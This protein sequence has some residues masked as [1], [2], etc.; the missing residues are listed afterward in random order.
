MNIRIDKAASVTVNV[1]LRNSVSVDDIKNVKVGNVCIVRALEEKRVYEKL[2]L[3]T[4]R[5]AKISKGDVIAGALGAR[6]AIQGFAG[7]M[8]ESLSRGD[9]L[10]ILN[11]GGVLGKAISYN[12]EYG[13]PLRV[14]LLGTAVKNGKP[15][16]IGDNAL[17]ISHHLE[18]EKSVP[19]V[20][21]S[22]TSMN[23]GKTEV[24]AKVTQELT[25][26]N[27][28]VCTAKVSGIAALKDVLHM[29]DHGAIKALSF[30][31]FGYPSTAFSRDVPLIAKGAILEL[32]R[33]NPDVIIIELGDGVLG[34]YG[35]LEFFKD[36]EIAGV[37]KCNVVCALDPV[38]AWGIVKIME[39]NG[40]PVHLV[41]GPVTDNVVGIDYISRSLKIVGLNAFSQKEELGDFIQNFVNK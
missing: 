20:V 33:Y 3:T 14:E 22:G 26:K 18:L 4:G 13:P 36:V 16:N 17:R 6:R 11:I 37:I 32:L 25:W 34:D 1:R 5:M 30:L 23:S 15:I 39:S 35:V 7:I 12:K 2:E 21:V 24:V 28:R 29:E 31:D 9:V 38:G 27:I 8:P 10:N 40:I 41:S 19:V